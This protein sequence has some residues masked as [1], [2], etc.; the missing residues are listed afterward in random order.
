MA[1][2]YTG[3]QGLLIERL[4]EL[5]SGSSNF[6]TLVGEATAAAAEAYI[7]ETEYEFVSGP[8]P[9]AAI[10]LS[11]FTWQGRGNGSFVND[12]GGSLE[13]HFEIDA[14]GADDNAKTRG[15]LNTVDDVIEDMATDSGDDGKI[16]VQSFTYSEPPMRFLDEYDTETDTTEEDY[17]T[18]T[19]LVQVGNIPV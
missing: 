12:Q 14:S 4:K 1:D 6:Q 3:R 9:F 8:R 2:D 19:F 11:D 18:V 7:H 10:W 16:V 15:F 5:L 17:F 13:L